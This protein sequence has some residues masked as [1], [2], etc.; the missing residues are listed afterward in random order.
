MINVCNAKKFCKEDLSK[1]E[2]YDKAIVFSE[3]TR[4]KMSEAAKRRC[5]KK[6][7]EF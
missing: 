2:N 4:K 6:K 7:G 1:I 5:S 3:E